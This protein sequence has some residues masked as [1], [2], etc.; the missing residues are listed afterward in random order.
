MSEYLAHAHPYVVHFA[1]VLPVVAAF[2]ELASVVFK[3]ESFSS[4]SLYLT[5]LAIPFLVTAV[6]TGNLAGTY[7]EAPLKTGIAGNHETFANITVW[8]VVTLSFGRVFYT[9]KKKFSGGLRL[10]YL[11]LALAAAF[12]TI[13]TAKLGGEIRH[14]EAARAL[15]RQ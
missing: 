8:L 6:L 3:R 2:F 4:T 14:G 5:I 12:F 9:V 13:Y 1:V 7:L 15:I 11:V 10:L